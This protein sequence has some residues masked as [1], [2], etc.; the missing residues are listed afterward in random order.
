MP[1]DAETRGAPSG[2]CASH[3]VQSC[4]QGGD[5]VVGDTGE[6]LLAKKKKK[7]KN[8]RDLCQR[9]EELCGSFKTR[10]S[11]RKAGFSAR[12][13]RLQRSSL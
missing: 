11:A 8:P 3:H 6:A 10:N 2:S 13:V 7:L 9:I 4:F 1:T 5:E 12:S